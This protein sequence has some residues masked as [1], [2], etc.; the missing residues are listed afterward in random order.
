MPAHYDFPPHGPYSHDPR[1][2]QSPA[3]L[4]STSRPTSVGILR[5]SPW[6]ISTGLDRPHDPD[7][8]ERTPIAR[9]PPSTH[10]A[11]P[12]AEDPPVGAKYECQYCGKGFNRPS[13]LKIHLNSHT[14]EKPFVC[15]LEG[16]GRSFSVLSNMRRHARVHTQPTGKEKEGL[17]DTNDDPSKTGGLSEH[18]PFGLHKNGG[19]PKWHQRRGS[20]ASTSSSASRRSRSQSSEDEEDDERP[21][22]RS[23]Q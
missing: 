8:E 9:Y 11:P 2:S 3:Y 23:R 13:S 1:L 5:P 15:P 17:S 14:G 4:P 6:P 18:S 16:C 7:D 12:F 19:D 20:I 10:Y 22:K 21:E